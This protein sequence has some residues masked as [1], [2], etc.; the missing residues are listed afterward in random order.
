MMGEGW[1]GGEPSTSRNSVAA[2]PEDSATANPETGERLLMMDVD[3]KVEVWNNH[4]EST[5]R[6]LS[7]SSLARMSL[8][9]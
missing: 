6:Y 4:C 9:L 8:S 1:D 2:K 3:H 5:L 7:R